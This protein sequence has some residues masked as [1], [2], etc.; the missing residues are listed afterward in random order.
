MTT[1]QLLVVDMVRLGWKY[2]CEP[3]FSEEHDVNFI[4]HGPYDPCSKTIG[5]RV[6]FV[7]GD[8]KLKGDAITLQ[9]AVEQAV[10]GKIPI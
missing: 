10:K 7:K 6:Y 1:Y 3:V 9:A 2:T 5:W 8:E 4:G